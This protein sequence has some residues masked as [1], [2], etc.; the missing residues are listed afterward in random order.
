MAEQGGDGNMITRTDLVRAFNAAR[1][2]FFDEV[3]AAEDKRI[4]AASKAK[5]AALFASLGDG[6]IVHYCAFKN[7]SYVR[8]V[9]E[10]DTSGDVG[11]VP[12]EMLGEWTECDTRPD[13]PWP[14]W[15][16]ERR[17]FVPHWAS[18]V[19]FSPRLHE[20]FEKAVMGG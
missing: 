5:G 14:R 8:C 7:R 17:P 18:V 20:G 11:L 19:E 15:I 6:Q 9:V 12:M 16:R 4:E 10:R 1:R 3:D 13:D 2:A